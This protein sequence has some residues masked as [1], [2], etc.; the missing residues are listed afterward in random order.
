M[1]VY[2]VCGVCYGATAFLPVILR[3]LFTGLA[4]LV[5]LGVYQGIRVFT[6]CGVTVNRCLRDRKTD[7]KGALGSFL[8]AYKQRH[9]N[10][11]TRNSSL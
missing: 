2:T 7:V 10:C 1:C 5:G 4:L 9:S 8:Q 6:V 3:C 11:D